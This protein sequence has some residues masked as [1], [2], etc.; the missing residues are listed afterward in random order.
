M[1]S[2]TNACLGA[3]TGRAGSSDR[4]S[5]RHWRTVRPPRSCGAL[6]QG[7]WARTS[8]S[9]YSTFS[10]HDA[11]Y[12]ALYT[13]TSRIGSMW[14]WTGCSLLGWR[15][16]AALRPQTMISIPPKTAVCYVRAK[17]PFPDK[18]ARGNVSLEL[19]QAHDN[20]FADAVVFMFLIPLPFHPLATQRAARTRRANSSS[21][22][23][24]CFVRH[25]VVPDLTHTTTSS[26]TAYCNQT[27]GETA[28]GSSSECPRTMPAI[29][30]SVCPA[31]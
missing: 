24:I 31:A 23:R 18:G 12:P 27:V 26:A 28:A 2:F 5:R 29:S 1:I 8:A 6:V 11:G 22:A 10:G 14:R 3:V 30:E 4:P 17:S 19:R 9:A 7:G 16:G 25:G 20:H 15:N 13:T 21:A